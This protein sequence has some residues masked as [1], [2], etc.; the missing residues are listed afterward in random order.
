[1][2]RMSDIETDMLIRSKAQLS[3]SWLMP[4]VPS[5]DPQNLASTL[6]LFF[7]VKL[8]LDAPASSLLPR[9]SGEDVSAMSSRRMVIGAVEW[10]AEMS[11]N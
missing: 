5:E 2:N 6:R 1:M 9:L 7:V 10:I 3:V 11:G 4:L 8:A